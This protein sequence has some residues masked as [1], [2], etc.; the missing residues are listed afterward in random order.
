M[1]KSKRY[2]TKM[3]FRFP[4]CRLIHKRIFYCNFLTIN[5]NQNGC[6]F[7][8]LDDD[9]GKGFHCSIIAV[10]SEGCNFDCAA[11]KIALMVKLQRMQ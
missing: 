6:V 3:I 11:L 2:E 7:R 10:I 8:N 1:R 4:V 5:N 9:L